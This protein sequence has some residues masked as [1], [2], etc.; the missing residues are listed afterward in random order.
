MKTCP[1]VYTLLHLTV[2]KRRPQATNTAR[3]ALG[4]GRQIP[5]PQQALSQAGQSL[6]GRG[7]SASVLGDIVPKGL[8]QD[9]S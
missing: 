2:T 8:A 4:E 7:L 3:V 1:Q 9:F 6:F 5:A